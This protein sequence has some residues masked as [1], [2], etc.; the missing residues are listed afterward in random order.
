MTWEPSGRWAVTPSYSA[1]SCKKTNFKAWLQPLLEDGVVYGGESA[2][3]VLAGPTLRGVQILD[4]PAEAVETVWEGLGL[5]ES[6][7]IPHWDNQKYSTSL[8]TAR[9][10]M[11]QYCPTITL[12]DADVLII[13]GGQ[14]KVVSA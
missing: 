6:G 10:E 8:A 12:N 14:Q 7:I 4:D 9:K 5:I 1:T 11:D 2:G 3:A 13:E